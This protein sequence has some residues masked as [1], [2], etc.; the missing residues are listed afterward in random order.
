[1]VRWI[2]R[3]ILTL[4]VLVALLVGVLFIVPGERIAAIAAREFGTATGR[5]M[6]IEG[7]VRA[8]IYPK[9]GVRT[10]PIEIANAD[11]SDAG[12]MLKAEGM[13]VGV[14]LM[15]LLSGNIK[16]DQVEAIAPDILLE[17]AK[18]GRANWEFELASETPA[19]TDQA[20]PESA[21]GIPAF[22]LDHGLATGGSLRF[23]DHSGGTDIVL[24][25]MDLDLRVPDFNGTSQIELSARMNGQ[26]NQVSAEVS[27]FSTLLA[28]DIVGFEVTAKSG[29]SNIGL[30]GR[31]GY[32]PL[33]FDGQLDAD[34]KDMAALFTTIGQTVPDVSEGLGQQASLSGKVTYTAEG[35]AHLRDGIIQLDQNT[36]NGEADLDLS[37]DRP[38]LNAQ[39]TA[40][41]LDFSSLAASADGNSGSGSAGSGTGW[42]KD[43]IDASG[44]GLLDAQIA[45]R[46]ASIDLGTLKLGTSR[47]LATLDRSRLV[48]EMREINAYRGLVT[49]SFVMNNRNG[50]SVGGDLSARG[51]AMQPMLIDL[52]DYER[53]IG[54]ADVDLQFLGVGNTVD[55][56]MHSLS[57]QGAFSIG[58]GELLGLDLVGMLRNFDASYQGEGSKTIFDSINATFQ[59][60]NGVLTNDDL[61][62]LGP[63]VRATGAGQVGIGE[64][65]LNYRVTPVALSNEDGTGG[66]T[67]PVLITGT[68]ADP[69]FRPDLQALIDQNLAE[70]RAAI[71]A[72]IE[73][74]RDEAEERL[75][76]QAEERLGVTRE[77]GESAE[78]A[79]KRR[80]Q[81]EAT[82]GLRNL[83]GGN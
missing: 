50:L 29:G 22:T 82:Q 30:S 37:G 25:E 10:G 2:I 47:V 61:V 5:A 4:I 58:S 27:N 75:R 57:G 54:L 55:A 14:D 7:E 53:L 28:G 83:L 38:K 35:T 45:F 64:Q 51:M 16:I 74:E 39:F 59:I 65:T 41:A 21:G 44:F 1:V 36:L 67:V 13:R 76:Q 12:P 48:F 19:A 32:E 8:S 79:L 43:M 52:A 9:L 17:V 3:F 81:E 15:S 72:R 24:T 56:I 73:A 23:L 68:W 18:D 70:E 49:G 46:A 60:A 66:I 33:T 77:E 11:W 78:D 26:V 62:F 63:L 6:K 20:V 40:E 31:G 69:K 34:L 42:S 71:E 80:L